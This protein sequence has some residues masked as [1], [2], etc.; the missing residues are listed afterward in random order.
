PAANWPVPVKWD[1]VD[2]AATY[3]VEVEK[4]PG[5]CDKAH[6]SVIT[7]TVSDT[8]FGFL[9]PTTDPGQVRVSAIVKGKESAPSA[10][11]PLTFAP[12]TGPFCPRC[13]IGAVKEL[14]AKDPSLV[15]P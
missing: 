6:Q 3:R 13:Y 14:V 11:R 9:Y 15:T 4:C 5:G 2:P 8:S 7:S 10:W 1:S 12:N